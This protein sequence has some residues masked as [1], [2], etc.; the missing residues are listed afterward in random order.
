MSGQWY[1]VPKEFGVLRTGRGPATATAPAGPERH[2]RKR[3][4]PSAGD[5]LGNRG[6]IRARLRC[7]DREHGGTRAV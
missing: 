2:W 6:A 3:W 7:T 4:G 5:G 1:A